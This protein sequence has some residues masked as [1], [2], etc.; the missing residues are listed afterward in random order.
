M[1]PKEKA[2]SLTWEIAKEIDSEFP[3]FESKKIALITVNEI[4]N[5]LNS[6]RISYG[7]EYRYEESDYW[8]YVKREIELL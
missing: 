3:L 7:G 5:A 1:T 8:I 6:E 4:L 2:I